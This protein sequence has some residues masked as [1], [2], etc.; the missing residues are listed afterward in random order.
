MAG[1]SAVPVQRGR[2]RGE[3][4]RRAG[5]AGSRML[6]L[7][8]SVRRPCAKSQSLATV[9]AVCVLGEQAKAHGV[10]LKAVL[11]QLPDARQAASDGVGPAAAV[12]VLKGCCHGMEA[13]GGGGK[14]GQE[15]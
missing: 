12:H 13:C 9:V 1:P 4:S 2:A 6:V 11:M 15:G 14:G 8:D 3:R 10:H 5:V 7:D